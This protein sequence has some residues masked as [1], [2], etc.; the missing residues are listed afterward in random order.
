MRARSKSEKK[1]NNLRSNVLFF[2]F[3]LGRRVRQ[4]WLDAV[5]ASAWSGRP[6][7]RRGWRGSGPRI[8]A[9]A[10]LELALFLKRKGR[11]SA[12]LAGRTSSTSHKSGQGRSRRGARQRSASSTTLPLVNERQTAACGRGT[13]LDG[14]AWIRRGRHVHGTRAKELKNVTRCCRSKTMRSHFQVTPN[15]PH[16]RRGSRFRYLS[17]LRIPSF[18]T[19]SFGDNPLFSRK[20]QNVFFFSFL[21]IYRFFG[22]ESTSA[23]CDENYVRYLYKEVSVT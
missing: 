3:V 11:R 15:A 14:A 10:K 4:H 16:L 18:P 20:V 7:P 23:N 12:S 8:G 9:K 6:S 21:T 2:F 13:M 19:R 1:L 17:P 5:V 22:V